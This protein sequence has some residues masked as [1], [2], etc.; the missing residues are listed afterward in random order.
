MD[1]EYIFEADMDCQC[2]YH[3]DVCDGILLTP[4]RYEGNDD[5]PDVHRLMYKDLPAGMISLFQS[6]YNFMKQ[7]IDGVNLSGKNRNG[8]LYQCMVLL[9][10]ASGYL[11]FRWAL[12]H[13][14]QIPGDVGDV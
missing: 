6:A 1:T 4:N 3:A 10:Y 9:V 2:G 7:E 8:E 5:T 12:Y 14:R 11:R 13:R